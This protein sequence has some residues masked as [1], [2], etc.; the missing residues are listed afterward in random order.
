[1]PSAFDLSCSRDR[2][3]IAMAA[4]LVLATPASAAETRTGA[5]AYGDWTTDS[6]GVMRMITAADL[7]PP[8]AT[9]IRPNMSSIRPQPAGA[10]PI[11]PPGFTAQV[12]AQ[13]DRPRLIRVAPNGDIFVSETSSGK[14]MVLRAADGAGKATETR[15]FASGLSEPFGIAFYPA[16]PDPHYIYIANTDSVVR[17]PYRNG[18]LQ[19][20]GKSETVAPTLPSGG[21][22]S[23]RDIAFSPDGKQLFISVGSATN[24]AET[25]S[26]PDPDRI[27]VAT[28]ER[29]LGAA[30]GDETLRADVLVTSP[31]GKDGLR[32][33]ANGIRNCVGLAIQPETGGVWCATNERDSIGDN[34]PPDYVTQVRDG[35]FYG[36]PW[37]Y[38][39]NH[40]DPSHKGERTDLAGKV[41]I[42]DVLIQPHS[43][44]LEMAFYSGGQFPPE[45]RGDAFVALHG[46]WN[47]ANRT[48]YKIV[49]VPFRDGKATGAYED[50]MTGFVAANGDVWGRPV[51][52]AVAHD[53]ALLVTEDANGKLWRVAYTGPGAATPQGR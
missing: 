11:T 43:A 35:A 18:D 45:Y 16:G 7:P 48:G 14:V 53:G 46:S 51:G 13:L 21:G 12:F 15:T 8:F 2:I 10:A 9:P 40:E 28:A 47:R 17:Y 6:P 36:W 23:T 4:V 19:A 22:H 3:S 44:P 33:F 20:E 49:R 26:K 5:A 32:S 42:P 38:I 39:G 50:F 31:D 24:V 41:T 30:W 1:M 29:G 27:R 52:V 37:Y 34:L 25:M